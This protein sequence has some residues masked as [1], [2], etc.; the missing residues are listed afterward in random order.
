MLATRKR[1]YPEAERAYRAALKGFGEAKNE[2]EYAKTAL[3]FATMVM[4]RISEAETA[5]TRIDRR[6]LSDAVD[7]L[8]DAIPAFR[9]RTML[10]EVEEAERLLYAL[11]RTLIRIR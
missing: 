1:D 5:G 9:G 2:L 3:K 10:K 11:Q 4:Q 6:E 8:T 7:I